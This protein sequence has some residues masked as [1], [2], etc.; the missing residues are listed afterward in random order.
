M[1]ITRKINCPYCEVGSVYFN[2]ELNGLYTQE[3]I[4]TCD[5]DMG[6]CDRNFVVKLRPS[7]EI[8][9]GRI[10]YDSKKTV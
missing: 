4:L 9:I 6:G 5:I 1:K 8:E 7:L 10:Q 3:K 2:M